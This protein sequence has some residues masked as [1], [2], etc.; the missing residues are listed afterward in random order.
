[1]TPP[2][3]PSVAE[4]T[5]ARMGSGISSNAPSTV[6]LS[7]SLGICLI[8]P[9]CNAE[10]RPAHNDPAAPAGWSTM[11]GQCSAPLASSHSRS[12]GSEVGVEGAGKGVS[13]GGLCSVG[14]DVM[15]CRGSST[16]RQQWGQSSVK[17]PQGLPMHREWM[18]DWQAGADGRR[19]RRCCS[20]RCGSPFWVPPPSLPDSAPRAAPPAKSTDT[21]ASPISEKLQPTHARGLQYEVQQPAQRCENPEL[22]SN[23]HE[24]GPV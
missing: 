6:R 5:N 17:H 11:V 14:E 18:P 15:R 21:P 22:S 12:V 8:T 10:M 13:R 20:S 1:M 3:T 24:F 7:P 23:M 16:L 9:P 19:S 4:S 2:Y